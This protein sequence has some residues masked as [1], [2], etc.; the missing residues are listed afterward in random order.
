MMNS[1][2]TEM[3][4]M[5]PGTSGLQIECG[6]FLWLSSDVGKLLQV[7][8]VTCMVCVELD[9]IHGGGGHG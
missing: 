7:M 3:S 4:E 2:N 9:F 5:I 1:S 8:D 6:L